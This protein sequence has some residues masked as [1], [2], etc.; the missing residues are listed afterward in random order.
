MSVSPQ[1]IA[2]FDVDQTIY[3]GYSMQDFYL[4]LVAQKLCDD[5]VAEKDRKIVR[6]YLAKEI[7]Y[8]EATNRVA[9]LQAEA[10]QGKSIAEVAKLADEFIESQGKLFPF[11]TELFALLSDAG[12]TIYLLS[13]ATNPTIEAIGR[14]LQTNNYFSSKLAVLDGTYTG[15]V[16]HMLNNE[17]KVLQMK[18]IL[19]DVP[20][21]S[22]T[23]G[24]GDSSGDMDMLTAVQYAFVIHAHEPKLLELAVQNNWRVVTDETILAEVRSII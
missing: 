24:F 20:S 3:H 15:V 2:F 4:Y 17:E 21:E 9:A 6:S 18:R 22:V 13:A 14:K 1:N 19:A 7:D 5:L 23:L 12:F 16:E 11:V 10:L 8:T